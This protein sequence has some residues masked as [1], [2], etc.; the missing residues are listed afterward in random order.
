VIEGLLPLPRDPVAG[1]A[2]GVAE[3]TGVEPAFA[4]AEM[5][6]VLA[7]GALVPRESEGGTRFAWSE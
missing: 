3:A 6:R 2:A 5:E 7:L 1:L 4:R